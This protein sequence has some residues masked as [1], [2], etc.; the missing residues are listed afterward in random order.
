MKKLASAILLI[1]VAP[2]GFAQTCPTTVSPLSGTGKNSCTGAVDNYGTVCGNLKTFGPTDVYLLPPVG[3]SANFTVTVTP[4]EATYDVAIY[5]VGPNACNQTTG[6]GTGAAPLDADAQGAGVAE[7]ITATTANGAA[8]GNY[9]LVVGSTAGAN[10]TAGGCG[11]YGYSV[12]G[13]LPV[14]LNKF[15]VD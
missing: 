14:T 5:L 4:T 8:A 15:A 7:S 10:E 13:D 12:T 3:G 9:Y 6:C 2:L 11:T 1:C